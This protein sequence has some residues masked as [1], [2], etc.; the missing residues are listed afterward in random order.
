MGYNIEK[1]NTHESGFYCMKYTVKQGDT[2]SSIAKQYLGD[3]NAYG[4]ISGYTGDERKMPVGIELDVPD[5]SLPPADKL[6]PQQVQQPQIQLDNVSSQSA[7]ISTPEQKPLPSADKMFES[8]TTGK[9]AEKQEEV[10]MPS[11][12]SDTATPSATFGQR[13]RKLWRMSGGVHRG[14]DWSVPEGTIVN[15]PSEGK[16]EVAESYTDK[17][18]GYGNTVVVKN[19]E[20]GETLRYSHLHTRIL[21]PGQVVAGGSSV[22]LTG[23]TGNS[24]APHLDLEYINEKGQLADPLKSKYSKYFK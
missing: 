14:T 16:W 15:I 13:N 7:A 12:F 20:T 24:T 10:E 9:L 17:K 3:P 22:G 5:Q 23:T 1:E 4:K 2:L 19:T 11:M 8:P 6:V 21:E 18:T